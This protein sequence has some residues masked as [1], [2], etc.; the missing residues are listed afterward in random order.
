MAENTQPAAVISK[1]LDITPRRLQ[2]LAQDGIV[3]KA[4]RGRYPLVGCGFD[5]RAGRRPCADRHMCRAGLTQHGQNQV[6][7][8]KLAH[9]EPIQFNSGFQ[10]ADRILCAL[11]GSER[12]FPVSF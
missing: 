12:D 1:L 11:R 3:P 6:N 5:F 2:Q 9:R 7:Q 8:G 4:D 10:H